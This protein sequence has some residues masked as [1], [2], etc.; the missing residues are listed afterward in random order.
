MPQQAGLNHVH[1]Q[2]LQLLRDPD[3]FVL[4]HRRAGRLL[5]IPQGGIE[6]DQFVG[7]AAL[8]WKIRS[9]TVILNGFSPALV[10]P[11]RSLILRELWGEG[12]S[13]R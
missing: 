1:P 6:Y 3:F 11:D 10:L 9:T 8:L 2:A 7:H 4:G 5:A 13:A 12:F